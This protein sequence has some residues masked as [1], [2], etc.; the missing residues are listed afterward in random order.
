[1]LFGKEIT[2]ENKFTYEV[3][4]SNTLI[5]KF[6]DLSFEIWINSGMCSIFCKSKNNFSEVCTEFIR[7]PRAK[8]TIKELFEYFKLRM[9]KGMYKHCFDDYAEIVSEITAHLMVIYML[10]RLSDPRALEEIECMFNQMG[11]IYDISLNESFF[12]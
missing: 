3:K 8:I 9:E 7:P 6:E 12:I 1:M 4:E 10:R 11:N 5:L 2:M